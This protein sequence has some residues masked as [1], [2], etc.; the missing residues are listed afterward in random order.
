MSGVTDAAEWSGIGIPRRLGRPDRDQ[1][2]GGFGDPMVCAELDMQE[3]AACLELVVRPGTFVVR[4]TGSYH[5]PGDEPME[6]VRW[7]AF[8]YGKAGHKPAT[9]RPR[10]ESNRATY[11]AR[12]THRH[13]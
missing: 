12:H 3:T 11:M 6:G 2:H 8:P 10:G 5:I 9:R 1:E 7:G 13:L 4:S